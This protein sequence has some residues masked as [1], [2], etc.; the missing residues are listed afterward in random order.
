MGA[1]GRAVARGKVLVLTATLTLTLSLKGE[2][3]DGAVVASG[4]VALPGV[5]ATLGVHQVSEHL[6]TMCPV[7]TPSRARGKIGATGW[8]VRLFGRSRG[9]TLGIGEL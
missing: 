3:K 7:W 2:G 9:G 6:S 8:W 5:D 1:V 4:G